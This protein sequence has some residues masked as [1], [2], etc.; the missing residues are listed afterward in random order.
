VYRQEKADLLSRKKS[1]EE[2]MTDLNK[3]A[4]SWLE[5]LR[6]WIKDAE[7]LRETVVSPSLPPKKSSA[8]KIFGSNLFLSNRLLVSTPTTPYASLREARLNF[9]ENDLCL[10]LERVT[11]IEPVSQPW[12]GRVL[13]LNHTRNMGMV[14]HQCAICK[15]SREGVV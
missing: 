5:P 11:G 15:I 9:S 10:K 12:E 14:T 4:I 6:G 8:Q 1:L 7:N 3:G 2:K 13:P